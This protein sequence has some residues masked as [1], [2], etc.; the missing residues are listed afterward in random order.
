MDLTSLSLGS[1]TGV[2][3]GMSIESA[4]IANHMGV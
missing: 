1:L 3:E 4:D 2:V